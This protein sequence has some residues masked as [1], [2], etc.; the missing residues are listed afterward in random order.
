M[1]CSL[2]LISC[3]AGAKVTDGKKDKR[4]VGIS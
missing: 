3:Y 4:R 1:V 2:F